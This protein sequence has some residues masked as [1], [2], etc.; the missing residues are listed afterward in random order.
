MQRI[1]AGVSGTP[2]NPILPLV[3]AIAAS[4]ATTYRVEGVVV[5][6]DRAQGIMIV[7]HK[8]IEG[9]MPAMMMPFR[10]DPPSVLNTLKS[11]AR[12]AFEL[13]GTNKAR[14]IRILDNAT[15]A[16]FKLPEPPNRLA[17]GT[18]VPDIAGLIDQQNRSIRFSDFRGQV[19]AI[20]FI[21]TRCPLPDVCPRQTAQ[22][23]YLHR[24]SPDTMLLTFTLDPTHDTPQVLKDYAQ[25]WN[26][27]ENWHFVTTTNEDKIKETGGLFG[28]IFWPEDGVITHTS[29]TAI[30]GK[31]G[32]LKAVVQGSSHRT[33]QI[34][35][36][37]ANQLR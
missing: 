3:F 21:Y 5:E 20:Q 24:K 16:D 1:Q 12:I 9:Y 30:I 25:R 10:A 18:E 29:A 22:F 19:V 17:L 27:N 34:A 32:K 8:P 31:D 33:E 26:A 23:A 4:A 6:V 15:V 7:S 14:K 28:V 37:I 36:L 13:S 11:G 2:R 35:D